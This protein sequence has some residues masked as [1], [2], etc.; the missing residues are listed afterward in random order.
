LPPLKLKSAY[1][2]N[3]AF[4]KAAEAALIREIRVLN[5]WLKIR[6]IDVVV[7]IGPAY[8]HGVAIRGSWLWVAIP[9]RLPAPYSMGFLPENCLL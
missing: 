4:P 5:S 7:N 2:R 6:L 1:E 9:G 3:A 8:F